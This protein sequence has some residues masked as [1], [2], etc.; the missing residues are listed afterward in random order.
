MKRLVHFI[1]YPPGIGDHD[2]VFRQRLHDLDDIRF[3][4]PESAQR[5]SGIAGRFLKLVLAGDKD[6]GNGVLPGAKQARDRVGSGAP[7]RDQ[8]G[9]YLLRALGVSGG[10]ERSRLLMV[11]RDPFD[12]FMPRD[13][14]GQIQYAAA[15]HHEDM[16]GAFI[17]Q[18]FNNV[19]RDSDHNS[20]SSRCLKVTSPA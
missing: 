3:L 11:H 13:G 8:A 2:G 4:L 17:V 9:A 6:A 18:P 12:L 20:V 15:R 14:V 19:I 10:R 5:Q 7:G 16:P 1:R